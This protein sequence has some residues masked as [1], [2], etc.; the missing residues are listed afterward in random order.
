MRGLTA[1]LTGGLLL[2]CAAQAQPAL[3]VPPIIPLPK[4]G[5]A[6]PPPLEP[7]LG[8][9]PCAPEKLV[10]MVVRNVSP[11][12][13]AASPVAQPRTLYRQGTTY[14]RSEES[15]DP[16]RGQP[17]VIISEPDIWT[18]NMATRTGRHQVDPGPELVVRAPI[19]PLTPDLP[20]DFR[21][22]EYGCELDFMRRANATEP[23]QTIPW[24]DGRATVHQVVAGEHVVSILLSDR[25]QEPLMVGYAKAGRPL[26]AVRYDDFRGNVPDRPGLFAPPQRVTIT[27]GTAQ[28]GTPSTAAP[29]P[30]PGE[31]RDFNET[32][33]PQRRRPPAERRPRPQI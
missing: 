26:F 32:P 9:P 29:R 19:L 18:V 17:V 7:R 25:A 20:A 13:A 21:T 31:A 6:A 24:G 11:G 22:L 28:A 15:P 23:K 4:A 5:P 1:S 3:D 8:P 33:Q 30:P 10:R 2:A 16:A 12:L 27:E 14:L